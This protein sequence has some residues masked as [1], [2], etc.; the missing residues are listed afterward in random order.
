MK[1]LSTISR[2]VACAVAVVVIQGCATWVDVEKFKYPVDLTKPDQVPASQQQGFRYTMTEPYLL[3]KPKS[4]GTATYEWIYLPD[5]NNEYVVSPKSIFATYKM[6]IEIENGFLTSA[7]FDGTAN[8]VAGK[9]AGV[10]GD[11]KAA[12]TTAESTAQKAAD[13]AAKTKAAADETAFNTKLAAAQKAVA[14]AEL[15]QTSANTEHAFY[16]FGAGKDAEAKV[17]QAAL[18]AKLK[19]DATLDLMKTRLQDVLASSSGAK[20]DGGSKSGIKMAMGPALF[21]L[22]QTANSVSL[23][24]VGTQG[25]FETAGARANQAAPTG[26]AAV[27]L[28]SKNVAKVGATTVVDFSSSSTIA[29][30]KDAVL[31]L[32]R[33]IETYD[34]SKVVYSNGADKQYKATF[35]PPLPAGDYTLVVAYDKT[36]SAQLSFTVK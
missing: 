26:A 30:V 27:T 3:V 8:E 31:T 16:E 25:L 35:S 32:N 17:K 12:E 5:R 20:D 28:T 19:A 24:Q 21:K 2:H 14:D 36:Q 29:I 10:V 15:A 4:D 11:V 23:V 1:L 22:V 18:L 34:K 6:T 33:G 13:T 7:G 9:L